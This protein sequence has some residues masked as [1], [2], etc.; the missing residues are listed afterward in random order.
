MGGLD[1]AAVR[2]LARREYEAGLA[3]QT[4]GRW[5]RAEARFRQATRLDGSM[6]EYQAALGKVFM[7]QRL[8][9][10]AEALF[11]AATLLEVENPEYRR[12]LTQARAS[13]R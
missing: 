12:L 1:V 11:T 9:T 2:R 4:A 8:W 10:E 7:H 6:A 3:E 13:K 5:S